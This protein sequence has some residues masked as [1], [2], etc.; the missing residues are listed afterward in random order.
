[1]SSL[2]VESITRQS[3][4]IHRAIDVER[5]LASELARLSA[6]LHSLADQQ[7]YLVG[8]LPVQR[9]RIADTQ[10]NEVVQLDVCAAEP[11]YACNGRGLD[12]RGEGRGI[13]ARVGVHI[14]PAARGELCDDRL[15][16]Q[17]WNANGH[18]AAEFAEL[19]FEK[20]R[21]H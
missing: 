9:Q 13:T 5:Q 8:L 19:D 15:Q 21:Y 1:M 20:D 14:D 4:F 2:P 3:A 10:V 6:K 18:F 11:A 16:H 12:P 7:V 17:I